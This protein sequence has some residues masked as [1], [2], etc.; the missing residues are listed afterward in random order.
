MSYTASPRP[1]F[2]RP[3]LITYD[4]A[5]RHLWGDKTSGQVSDWIYVSSN[6]IHQLV[7]GLAPGGWFRHSADYRT[8]F[9]ADEIY[10]VLSGVL[11]L[12]NPET[13]EVHRAVPGEAVFFRRDTWHHGYNQ[14]SEPLRVIEL[15]APPPAQGTS[16]AYA[17]TKPL[18]Q[19]NKTTQ[20]E[21]L[22]R[23][24]ME[25]AQPGSAVHHENGTGQ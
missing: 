15:F 11:A 4:A 17:R 20:D 19:T 10:Y 1:T 6:K 23:Y 9:A 3:T 18:L 7:F 8:I 13:G 5:S 22:G 16:S 2:D 14:S 25:H 21:W 12:N 24:P